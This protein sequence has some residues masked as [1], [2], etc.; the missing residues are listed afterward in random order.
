MLPAL[1]D[2]QGAPSLDLSQWVTDAALLKLFVER[3]LFDG[4]DTLLCRES[5]DSR[6]WEVLVGEVDR[7][8]SLKRFESSASSLHVDLI[9]RLLEGAE[10]EQ[11]DL[12]GRPSCID[13]DAYVALLGE[14]RTLENLR[15]W[16]G[17]APDDYGEKAL[18]A[19]MAWDRWD[20]VD[21]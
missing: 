4:L 16:W 2:R 14:Q 21:D 10:L 6:G 3:G 12:S 18:R 8:A 5:Y 7:L 11:L 20:E 1:V 19:M 15:L 9:S 17:W 13:E